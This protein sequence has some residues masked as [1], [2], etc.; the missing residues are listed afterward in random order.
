MKKISIIIVSA[1]T[2]LAL[3]GTVHAKQFNVEKRLAKMTEKLSLNETQQA[4]LQSFLDEKV[5]LIK[6]RKSKKDSM[7]KREKADHPMAKLMDKEQ[8]SVEEIYAIMDNKIENSRNVR[9][10]LMESFVIFYNSLN[11][12]QRTKVKPM[13]RKMLKKSIHRHGKKHA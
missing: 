4:N 10:N 8:I 13:L 12:E 11:A 3:A 5:A 6:L 9:Q 7:E 2:G 1:L